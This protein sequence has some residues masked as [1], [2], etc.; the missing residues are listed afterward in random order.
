MLSLKSLL[1]AS[2][3]FE[4]IG[5]VSTHVHMLA[6]GLQALGEEVRVIGEQPPR[7]Y[8][9]PLV[10]L[11]G[12]LLSKA[13]RR[14]GQR[15][16][17]VLTPSKPRGS[18]GVEESFPYTALEAMACG[19]P[20]IAYHTGG[21][22]EQI[23]DGQTVVLVTAGDSRALAAA[24]LR[25]TDEALKRRMGL[26][27][28]RHVEEHFSASDMASRFVDVYRKAARQAKGGR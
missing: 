8:R 4:E 11:P 3:P 19:I 15:W 23:K 2:P 28:R 18:G 20:V 17:L 16:A 7:I 12:L 24:A 13:S 25:F 22:S 5:G 27:A 1:V 9:A 14:L 26:N 6:G 10:S 21:L